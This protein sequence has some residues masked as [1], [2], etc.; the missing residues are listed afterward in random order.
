MEFFTEED[1]AVNDQFD[2]DVTFIG[3]E[4]VTFV[5]NFYKYPDRVRAYVGAIPIKDQRLPDIQL[6]GSHGTEYLCG[7]DYYD[8]KF[9][10]ERCRGP[11]PTECRLYDTL[12]KLYDTDLDNT[13]SFLKWRAFNQFLS[14]ND[15]PPDKPYFWPHT[16]GGFNLLVFLNPHNHMGAGTTLYKKVS[17]KTRGQEHVD[18]WWGTDDYEEIGTILDSYNTLCIF[19]GRIWH[20]MRIINGVHTQHP[21]ITGINYFGDGSKENLPSSS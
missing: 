5:D 2:L 21:R 15:H 4:M 8:G 1:F 20:A 18:S 14:V 17:D 6:R 13:G 9:Y 10:V 11:S 3:G 7:K 12:A 16:D 19:H